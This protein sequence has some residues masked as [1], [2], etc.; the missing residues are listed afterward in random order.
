MNNK[1]ILRAELQ[2]D[3]NGN[4]RADFPKQIPELEDIDHLIRA[5]GR[6]RAGMEPPAGDTQLPDGLVIPNLD[7]VNEI[8]EPNVGRALDGSS[9]L[10]LRHSSFGWLAFRLTRNS[11]NVVIDAL[12]ADEEAQSKPLPPAN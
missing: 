2:T 4:L 9:V 12:L 1:V 3:G 6:L 5:L 7:V 8:S 10:M 11:R